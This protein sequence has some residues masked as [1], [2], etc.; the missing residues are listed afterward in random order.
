MQCDIPPPPPKL[1]C[2]VEVYSKK[3]GVQVTKMPLAH[4]FEERVDASLQAV[5]SQPG[6]FRGTAHKRGF[7]LEN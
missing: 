4:E 6:L 2:T 1:L 5:G 7:A 3:L